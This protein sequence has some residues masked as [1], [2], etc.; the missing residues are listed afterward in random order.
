MLRQGKEILLLQ[1]FPKISENLLR[2]R[3][4]GYGSENLAGVDL[5][6]ELVGLVDQHWLNF[7][8]ASTMDHM[9]LG[10]VYAFIFVAGVFG[11]GC[12][13]WIFCT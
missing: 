12:V 8:P 6:P 10:V 9:I 5:P 13:L 7:A 4:S 3:S 1:Y 2:Y 11:N